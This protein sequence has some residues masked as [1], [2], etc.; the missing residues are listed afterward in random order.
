MA[1]DASFFGGGWEGRWCKACQ[2]PITSG[3]RFTHVNFEKQPHFT[4]HYHEPCSRPFRSMAHI[5][6]ANFGG[7]R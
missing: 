1:Y 7:G 6:N 4:G 2:Q 3:E 5:L